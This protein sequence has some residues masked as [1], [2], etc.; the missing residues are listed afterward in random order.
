MKELPRTNRELFLLRPTGLFIKHREYTNKMKHEDRERMLGETPVT[1]LF[2][3]MSLPAITGMIV[4]A[5]YNIADRYFIANIPEVGE[6]AISGV[7]VSL[8]ALFILLGFSMLFGIGS[9]AN[10]SIK[11]GMKKKEEAEKILGNGIALLLGGGFIISTG[12]LLGIDSLL[13]IY[14][15]SEANFSYAKDYLS[16]ILIG[17]Y[18]NMTA[19]G[20]SHLIRSEGNAKRAMMSM[21]IGAIS[22]VIL[23]PILIFGLGMGV[24]GAAIAT[25][26]AQFLSFA[27]G[28]SYYLKKKSSLTLHLKNFKIEKELFIA[29]VSI[30]FSPFFIQAAGSFIGALLNNSLKFYGGDL[31][32]GSYAIL[33]SISSLFLMPIFGMNQAL[34]PIIGYNYGAKYYDRVKKAVFTGVIAATIVLGF[35]TVVMMIFTEQIIGFMTPSPSLIE[36]SVPAAK[37]LFVMISLLSVQIISTTFFQS[38]GKARV[39]FFLS[40]SRQ[41][42]TLIPLILV[43][44]GIWGLNGIWI[45]FPISDAISFIF[46]LVL[47]IIQFRKLDALHSAKLRDDEVEKGDYQ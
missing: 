25:I 32:Q 31:A 35:A 5:L 10:I 18:W 26:I 15:A 19:F 23:D 14:G 7:G 20:L 38:I 47:L 29:I 33:S 3:K 11:M 39:S 27:W 1:E 17:N 40:L 42:L 24:K 45:S 8:P 9:A 36:A 12:F 21:L 13:S 30:G 46:A 2:L 37:Y 4:Q 41:V 6:I 22:N 34:Q 16:I 44:P 43:L 28:I